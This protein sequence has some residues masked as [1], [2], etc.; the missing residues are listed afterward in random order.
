MA[1]AT[2]RKRRR[3]VMHDELTDREGQ[4]ARLVA[5]GMSN[6]VIAE[7]LGVTDTT[8]KKHVSAALLKLGCENRVQLALEFLECAKCRKRPVVMR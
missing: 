1:R 6:R 3:I 4:V 7:R 2:P 8:V 5:K